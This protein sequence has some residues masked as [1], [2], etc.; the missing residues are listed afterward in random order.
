MRELLQADR[1]GVCVREGGRGKGRR[2]GS[3]EE[4]ATPKLRESQEYRWLALTA[5]ESDASRDRHRAPSARANREWHRIVSS[6]G[7]AYIKKAH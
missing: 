5:L 4:E 6:Y 1:G 2:K 7:Q 3:G